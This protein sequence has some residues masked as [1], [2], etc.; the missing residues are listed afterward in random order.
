MAYLYR[1]PNPLVGIPHEVLM[2]NVDSFARQHE[3]VEIMPFLKKGALVAQSPCNPTLIPELDNADQQVIRE[4]TT[5]RWNHP[6]TMYY[7][8]ILSSIAAII[9]EWDQTGLH[10]ANLTLDVQFG[11]PTSEPHCPDDATCARNQW[12]VG[13]VNLVPYIAIFLFAA[14][15]SDPINHVLGRKGTILVAAVFNLLAPIGSACSQTWGQLVACRFLLGIGM[16]LMEVTVPVYAA[17][18][19]PINIR[20]SL[21]M[22]WQLWTAF[23][24]FLGTCGDLAMVGIGENAWR[25]KLGSAFVPVVPLF[26]GVWFCPE[27]PRWLITKGKYYR[28]YKSLLKLRNSPLQAARDLH[29]IHL[30][31][32][33]EKRMLADSGASETDSMFVRFVQLFRVPHLRRAI[34]AS[35]IM[36]G[37]SNIVTLVASVGFGLINFIAAWPTVWTIDTF[38][39]RSLLLSTFPNMCWTL[40]AAGFCFW[41]PTSSHAHISLIVFFIYLFDAFYSPG[42]GPVPFT[43]SAEVFP[44]THREV[45]MAWAVATNNSWASVLCPPSHTCH[46]PS[47]P[48]EHLLSMPVS[49]SSPYF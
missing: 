43:Y 35:G 29:M 12:I 28:A 2:E 4:E 38:G 1:I 14:W 45:G 47:H 5:D 9:Q 21:V 7:T 11:I 10:G 32:E 15:L 30:Q 8:I 42:E 41:V 49:I 26:I 36:A 44:L 46:E 24:I 22:S 20:G 6:P 34:Q 23:G 17:E 25:W 40:L 48:R 27:S 19:A 39:R 31:L 37:A 3:L 16:G 13:F 33:V 18:N